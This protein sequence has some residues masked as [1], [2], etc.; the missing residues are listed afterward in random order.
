MTAPVAERQRAMRRFGA[1]TGED[2]FRRR[3]ARV[4]AGQLA[5]LDQQAADLINF[6]ASHRGFAAQ[7]GLWL[8]P[9][10]NVDHRAGEVRVG[11]INERVVEVPWA[12][13]ALGP[14][15][16]GGRVLDFGACESQVSLSLA[17][18]GYR[19]TALDLHPYPF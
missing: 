19:V 3:M 10:V 1:D 11:A 15:P 13:R 2:D 7:A 4:A 18:M 17:A 12:M 5:D 14:V 16:L 9:A 6:A 8:N